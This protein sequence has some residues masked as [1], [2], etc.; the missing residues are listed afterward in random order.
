MATETPAPMKDS[1]NAD[2]ARANSSV[3]VRTVRPVDLEFRSEASEV[4][5]SDNVQ[6][7]PDVRYS[8]SDVT[9][10]CACSRVF[11]SLVVVA[12]V[13]GDREP[14]K[15]SADADGTA[16]PIPLRLPRF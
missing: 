1:A 2:G 6:D 12:V 5:E 13:F 14:I 4:K 10:V 3:P 7:V 16:S 8:A 11:R 15:E 9:A